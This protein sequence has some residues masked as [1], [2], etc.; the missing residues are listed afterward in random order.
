MAACW[1]VLACVAGGWIQSASNMP[2]N[3]PCDYYYQ[4]WP[5]GPF[6][7]TSPNAPISLIFVV[8]P[9]CLV[10][11]LDVSACRQKFAFGVKLLLVVTED[12]SI[13]VRVTLY[14][15]P[16]H[17]THNSLSSTGEKLGLSDTSCY[18]FCPCDLVVS[19]FS[20]LSRARLLFKSDTSS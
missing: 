12:V 19:I 17:T 13:H 7:A 14:P 20:T 15:V 6:G 9:P 3:I 16:S 11:F 2:I 1:W 18:E 5:K 4:F 8:C 10:R